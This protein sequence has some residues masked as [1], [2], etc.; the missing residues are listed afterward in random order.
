MINFSFS[1]ESADHNLRV[2][3]DESNYDGGDIIAISVNVSEYE[4]GSIG[5][6][7][8]KDGDM[9]DVNQGEI[10]FSGDT[11][12]I[13]SYI[14]I[15]EGPSWTKGTYVVRAEHHGSVGETSFNVWNSSMDGESPKKTTE[16]PKKRITVNMEESVFYLDSPN[17]IIRGTIEI[18][19]YIPSDGRYFMTV[20]HIST[21]KVLKD[22]QI[23]P[24]PVG[25]DLW[26]VPIAY[27]ILESDL[28][29]G[30]QML[31]GDFEIHISTEFGIQTTNTHFSILESQN[32]SGSQTQIDPP[33]LELASGPSDEFF[34]KIPGWIK[35]NAG[36]WAN[37]KISEPEF[38]RAIEYLIKNDI[39]V[40]SMAENG[41]LPPFASTYL[42]PSKDSTEEG[43]M[44]GR[45][46]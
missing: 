42:R 12:V 23:F 25:N 2:T 31:F 38:L 19:N 45:L 39:M 43:E 16:P 10:T 28:K 24:K 33:S 36:W 6:Q 4:G 44:A 3:T 29:V 14:T 41:N 40:I 11:E 37:D 7:I 17:K 15:A 20:T 30:D 13:Y 8:W 35:I 21:N 46:A 9:I 1:H 22:F 26:A 5:I 34:Q 18:Q 32:E 27:P